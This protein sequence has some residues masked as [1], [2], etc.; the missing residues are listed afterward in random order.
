MAA[1]GGQVVPA[2]FPFRSQRRELVILSGVFDSGTQERGNESTIVVTRHWPGQP[3]IE[4]YGKYYPEFR[5]VE[6]HWPWWTDGVA[7]PQRKSGLSWH[8]R[9]AGAQSRRWFGRTDAVCCI[10]QCCRP[11]RCG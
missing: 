3:H 7:C 6:Y 1:I 4:P 10:P 11:W 2:V 8:S 9:I 5:P